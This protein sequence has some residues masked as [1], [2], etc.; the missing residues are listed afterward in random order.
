MNREV[1]Y[2]FPTIILCY[3]NPDFLKT[4]K[5]ITEILKLSEFYKG[6]TGVDQTVDNHLHEHSNFKDLFNWIQEC[7]TDYKNAFE[8]SCDGLAPCISWVNKSNSKSEHKEHTHPNSYLSGIYYLSENPSPTYFA[9]PVSEQIMIMSNRQ[10][11]W[12]CFGNAG[13]LILFPSTLLHWTQPQ[14]FKGDRLTLSFNAMPTGVVN[15]QTLSEC[16]Y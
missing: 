6:T 3:K 8:L 14:P 12:T 13:D 16:K 5:K 4:N 1:A 2:I 11:V 9:S 15:R 7:I 10:D